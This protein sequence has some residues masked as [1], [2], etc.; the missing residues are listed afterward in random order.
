M[1]SDDMKFIVPP[2]PPRMQY[3]AYA[4]WR[5]QIWYLLQEARRIGDV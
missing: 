3:W 1:K 4:G 5:V 2:A